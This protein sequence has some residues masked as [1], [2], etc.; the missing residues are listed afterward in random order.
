M[1]IRLLPFL[2]V[3]AFL[4]TNPAQAQLAAPGDAGDLPGVNLTFAE[5]ETVNPGTRGRALDHIGFEVRDLARLIA[6]LEV[7]GVTLDSPLRTAGNGTTSIAF[8]TALGVP[9][10]S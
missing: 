2:C 3:V 1:N 8:L 5:A 7:A 10:S 9:T 4:W 6:R